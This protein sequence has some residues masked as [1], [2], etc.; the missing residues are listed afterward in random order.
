MSSFISVGQRCGF[1]SRHGNRGG[2]TIAQTAD[3]AA[4]EDSAS[5]AFGQFVLPVTAAIA[6]M[7]VGFVWSPV[8]RNVPFIGAK[9]FGTDKTV[10][11]TT[12]AIDG[13]AGLVVAASILGAP[14]G[15]SL[16][17]KVGTVDEAAAS[18]TVSTVMSDWAT[19]DI[20]AFVTTGGVTR[21]MVAPD[22][23][24]VAGFVFGPAFGDVAKISMVARG[25]TNADGEGCDRKQPQ[26]N[27]NPIR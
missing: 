20:S 15:F 2:A 3:F 22:E 27:D 7:N 4:T 23:G 17:S 5:A 16:I 1:A 12:T 14:V 13:D 24:S 26:T 18:P 8:I 19:L 6:L 10:P 25:G 21:W 11:L 9:M